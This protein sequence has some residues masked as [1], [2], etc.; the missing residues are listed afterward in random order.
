MAGKDQD[1]PLKWLYR[2]DLHMSAAENARVVSC[3]IPSI[4]SETSKNTFG[5]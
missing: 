5:G 2:H 1:F 4:R 3:P